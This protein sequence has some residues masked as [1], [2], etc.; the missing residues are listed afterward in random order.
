M[1][2]TNSISMVKKQNSMSNVITSFPSTCLTQGAVLFVACCCLV[3]V[4][5]VVSS[6]VQVSFRDF[7]L[8]VFANLGS[9]FHPDQ[10]HKN[11]L[12]LAQDQNRQKTLPQKRYDRHSILPSVVDVFFHFSSSC[13]RSRSKSCPPQGGLKV[14]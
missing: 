1:K 11:I 6:V 8:R 14:V 9:Q 2:F 3:V 13:F 12:M 10:H 7:C 5:I 4:V